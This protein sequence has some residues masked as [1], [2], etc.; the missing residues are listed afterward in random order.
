[1]GKQIKAISA[2]QRRMAV[3]IILRVKVE[4]YYLTNLIGV[5]RLATR[6]V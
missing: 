6:L 3:L 5:G 1:M 4:L 2:I